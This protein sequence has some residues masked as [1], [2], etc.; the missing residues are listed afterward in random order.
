MLDYRQMA[1][2][3]HSETWLNGEEFVSLLEWVEDSL[4]FERRRI[5]YLFGNEFTPRDGVEAVRFIC[6]FDN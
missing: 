4:L 6:W 2:D 1:C 5:G 3:A